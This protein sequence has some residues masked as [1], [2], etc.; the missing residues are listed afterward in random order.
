MLKHLISSSKIK[1][2]SIGKEK[3][4][5]LGLI[6]TDGHISK[7]IKRSVDITIS[8]SYSANKIK[9]DKIYSVLKNSNL[10]FSAHIQKEKINIL[11][12]QICQMQIFR[13]FKEDTSWIY[14]WL[15]IN[16]T[17]KWKL[18]KLN[19]YELMEIFNAMMLADGCNSEFCDQNYNIIEFF[20]VLCIFLGYNTTFDNGINNKEK[21][22]RTYI[23]CRREWGVQK[24]EISKI[25]YKGIVWCPQTNNGNFIAKRNGKIFIT[26]NSFCRM[27]VEKEIGIRVAQ[28]LLGHK[29]MASTQIYYDVDDKIARKI[30]NKHVTGILE[31]E[32]EQ[33]KEV[34]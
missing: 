11:N 17:P 6:M 19:Y 3:A 20:R 30:Y 14:D 12:D 29:N 10:K 23:S 7:G 25:L 32:E 33:N 15:N 26:G 24:N 13:I 16:G 18:L 1:G 22:L 4:F 9:C 8:Q 27:L 34:I 5:I 31:K 28:K 2:I 21:K